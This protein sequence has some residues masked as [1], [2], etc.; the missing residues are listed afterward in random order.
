MADTTRAR[1]VWRR[2]LEATKVGRNW[3]PIKRGWR[4]LTDKGVSVVFRVCGKKNESTSRSTSASLLE[5]Q[6]GG[7]ATTVEFQKFD[8]EYAEHQITMTENSEKG[9]W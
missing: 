8:A 7:D 6:E 2:E 9:R 4:V 1:R 3:L 5:V